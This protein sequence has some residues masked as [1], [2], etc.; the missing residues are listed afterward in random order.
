MIK[1]FISTHSCAA[2]AREPCVA[3]VVGAEKSK[4]E[5]KGQLL[6]NNCLQICESAEKFRKL[7]LQILERSLTISKE[8][9]RQNDLQQKTFNQSHVLEL[10]IPYF[11]R[12][13][14][15]FEEAVKIPTMQPRFIEGL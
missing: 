7:H 4:M 11:R 6:Y 3:L 1:D 13:L 5:I 15:E 12:N 2:G 14:A 8:V 10:I 9:I